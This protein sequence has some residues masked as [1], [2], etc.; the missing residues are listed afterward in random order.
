MAY[1]LTGSVY[2]PAVQPHSGSSG[3]GSGG[4]TGAAWEVNP[5]LLE[6]DTGDWIAHYGSMPFL[7]FLPLPAEKAA[8][9]QRPGDTVQVG[10]GGFM[11]QGL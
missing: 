6:P 10:G 8:G 3:G 1:L 11:G 7:G 4:S 5:T 2:P 9:L